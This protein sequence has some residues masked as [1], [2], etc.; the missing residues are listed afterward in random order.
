MGALVAHAESN[1]DRHFS[2]AYGDGVR[3]SASG[4]QARPGLD[5]ILTCSAGLVPTLE[6]VNSS[7]TTRSDA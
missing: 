2:C 5:L 4:R 3:F 1:S 6:I 7:R